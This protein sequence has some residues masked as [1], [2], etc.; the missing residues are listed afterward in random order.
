MTTMLDTIVPR[1]DQLNADD[2]IGG[3]TLTITVTGVDI[4]MA[5]QPVAVRFEGDNGKPYK[6]G[7]S[8]RRV[9]VHCWG[10]D[11]NLYV[12]RSLTLYRDDTVKFGGTD[13]G[14]I[15]ISHMS[16]LDR[17]TTMALTET[18][19]KRRPFTV[20]PLVPGAKQQSPDSPFISETLEQLVA[21]A[22]DAPA[23]LAAL[24]SALAAC[25]TVDDL[26]TLRTLP[27]VQG[28]LQKAPE[29]AKTQI[30][31]AIKAAEKRL[32]P[33][34]GKSEA[35]PAETAAAAEAFSA[36]TPE[37][38]DIDAAKALLHQLQTC[39]TDATAVKL[40]MSP[41]TKRQMA[42]YNERRPDL[43]RMVEGGYE[44]HR[45]VLNEQG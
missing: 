21:K 7:K 17:V 29:A 19:A 4:S 15:R 6:P 20:K 31:D 12:G 45:K 9:L 40:R 43:F 41:E 39:E 1:S 38:A 44:A 25:P 8:M 28:A 30:T 37:D 18:K 22:K 26:T 32:T 13:V 24:V 34:E 3:R 33:M 16:H 10:D 36:A 35:I 5:E 14:G 27:Q 11:A 23:W 2:L 42:D